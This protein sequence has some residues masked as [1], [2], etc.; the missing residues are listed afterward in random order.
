MAKSNKASR[1]EPRKRKKQFDERSKV[2]SSSLPK[3]P[4]LKTRNPRLAQTEA[5]REYNKQRAR[6]SGL[7]RRARQRGYDFS[8][9]EIPGRSTRHALW[10]DVEALQ[11]LTPAEIYAQ[12]T[13]LDRL[14]GEI[15]SGTER[16]KQ[17]RQAAYAKGQRTKQQKKNKGEPPSRSAQILEYIQNAIADYEARYPRGRWAGPTNFKWVGDSLRDFVR[18]LIEEEGQDAVIARLN[19]HP[20]VKD[21]TDVILFDSDDKKAE[22]SLGKF[23]TAMSGRPLTADEAETFGND[24]DYNDDLDELPL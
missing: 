6:I 24:S 16:R 10:E 4:K 9:F 19:E 3:K 5:D 18:M 22:Q 20:E 23:L 11:A 14:T 1:R 13:Y 17:E 21:Y 2:R 15:I 7:M 12:A 8:D